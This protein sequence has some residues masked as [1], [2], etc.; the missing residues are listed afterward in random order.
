MGQENGHHHHDQ[1][2]H[3]DKAAVGNILKDPVC[4]MDV[5][6]DSP[7]YTEYGGETIYFCSEHCLVKFQKNPSVYR[8]KHEQ[9]EKSD[10]PEV[11]AP[12]K[13]TDL[14]TCPMHP[15]VLQDRPGSC[16]KCGMARKSG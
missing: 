3:P 7:H 2:F 1:I 9:P 12:P 15:E 4:D 16:P 10:K 5:G 6:K 11:H 8:A 14:Y 13:E